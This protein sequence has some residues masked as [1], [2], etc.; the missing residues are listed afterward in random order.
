VIPWYEYTA[1]TML[2][3]RMMQVLGPTPFQ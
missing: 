1:K 3:G 2:V